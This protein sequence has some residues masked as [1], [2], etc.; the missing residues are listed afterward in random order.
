MLHPDRVE[1]GFRVR[2]TKAAC[3]NELDPGNLF[4]ITWKDREGRVRAT[5][6]PPA[7]TGVEANI[8]VLLGAGFPSGSHKVGPAYTTLMEGW[9]DGTIIPGRHTI[10]GPST[11]NFGI[12]VAYVCRLLG[13][14]SIIIMPDGMS[15]ERY[16]RIRAYGGELELT[17]GTESDVILTLERTK[18]L[19]KNPDYR[20]LA[21]F[22]LFPNYR[23]HRYVTGRSAIE[24][25]R[26]WGN[27]AIAGFA[28][29]PG[30]AGTLAAGD[31]IKAAFPTAKVAALEPYECP[32]LAT[33]G[34]GQHRI[35]GIGDKMCTLIHNVLNTDFVILVH[36]DHAVKGLKVLRDGAGVLT[37]WGLEREEAAALRES[38]GVSGVCNIL[39]AIQ[40]AKELGLGPG[41]NVVT[42]ATDGFDR[43]PSVLEDLERRSPEITPSVL[44]N[45]AR[46]V[47]RPDGPGEVYDCRGREAKERLFAQKAKDWLPFGYDREYLEAMQHPAFWEREYSLVDGYDAQLLARRRG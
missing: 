44:E 27:G 32:T 11:G 31:E 26:E 46:E 34:R 25:A 18:E 13:Y 45:W 39:G 15:R 8:I 28:A 7:L 10:L 22:E 17:P 21:Q 5:V 23:F 20:T 4:N 30:S 36:D 43:Y 37:G 1:P 9:V 29:A 42:V 41:E 35:E 38:F 6:L 2:A 16:E 19:A 40:L 14:R 12:G 3:T 47:F 33:G 24:A